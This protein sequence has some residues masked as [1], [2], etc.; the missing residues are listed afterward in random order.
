MTVHDKDDRAARLQQAILLKRAGA[1][2]RAP[3]L[4]PRPQ[5]EPAALGEMQ[6]GLW[7]AHQMAP[8]SPAYNLA[9]AFRVRGSLDLE[10]LQGALDAVVSRH[11]LL[12]STFRADGDARP[13]GRAPP[14]PRSRSR[15]VEAGEGGGRAAAARAAREPFDLETG[16]LVRLRLVEETPGS[17]RLL[18]LVLHHILADERS[19]G[20]LWKELAEAYEGRLSAARPA[21]PVRRLRAL[22][23]VDRR[24][25]TREGDRLLEA[26]PGPAAGRAEA[27]L[28][29]ARRGGRRVR[30]GS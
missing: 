24:R 12:R 3:E 21:G 11:R 19:L 18:L 7:L 27:A 8:R 4:P 2:S 22:A 10:R 20:F 17:E 23:A 1:R 16:P 25:G 15:T 9:S 13:A 30:G 26:A 5:D 6:Q 14:C 29:E 28:R